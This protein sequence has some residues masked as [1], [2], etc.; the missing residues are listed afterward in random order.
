MKTWVGARWV[1]YSDAESESEPS[2][3]EV[4][5][6]RL[7]GSEARVYSSGFMDSALCRW[8]SYS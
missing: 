8:V 2:E 4:W 5:F 7:P 1:L 6:Y 3:Y